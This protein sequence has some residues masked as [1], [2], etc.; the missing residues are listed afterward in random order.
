MQFAFTLRHKMLF[1]THTIEV[2]LRLA[3]PN[4]TISRNLKKSYRN[5]YL[6]SEI[7]ET[8]WLFTLLHMYNNS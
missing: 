5:I 2:S 8:R 7:V 6:G 3:K 4:K 1:A